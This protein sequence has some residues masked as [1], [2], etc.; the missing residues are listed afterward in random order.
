MDCRLAVPIDP[1]MLSAG[2]QGSPKAVLVSVPAN[3]VASKPGPG[4]RRAG[5]RHETGGAVQ[6][7]IGRR[8]AVGGGPPHLA[9]ALAQRGPVRLQQRSQVVYRVNRRLHQLAYVLRVP[10]GQVRQVTLGLLHAL[11]RYCRVV[12][13]ASSPSTGSAS[14]AIQRRAA[15]STRCAGGARSVSGSAW[16]MRV[17]APAAP[18]RRHS[19]HCAPS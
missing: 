6:P 10:A 5:L 14:R 12:S 15:A 9:P 16:A 13:T 2:S 19:P 1:V 11:P 17:P 7:G 3:Q 18:A 4:M 8:L